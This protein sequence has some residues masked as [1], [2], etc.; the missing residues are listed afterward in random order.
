MIIRQLIKAL[1]V[2][3]NVCFLAKKTN[4]KLFKN[5]KCSKKMNV[6]KIFNYLKEISAFSNTILNISTNYNVEG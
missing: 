1:Y 2:C 4:E 5:S 3:Q 6:E